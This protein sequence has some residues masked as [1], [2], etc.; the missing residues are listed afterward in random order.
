[1]SDSSYGSYGVGRVSFNSDSILEMLNRAHTIVIRS[2]SGLGNF[3]VHLGNVTG[4]MIFL[5]HDFSHSMYVLC[6]SQLPTMEPWPGVQGPLL[7]DSFL[8]S[9]WI[10][11]C[12]YLDLPLNVFFIILLSS[13]LHGFLKLSWNHTSPLRKWI[14][15]LNSKLPS[16]ISPSL[17]SFNTYLFNLSLI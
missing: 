14:V 4:T 8:V 11:T 9:S 3:N 12:L 10:L 7:S 15:S 1:M 6:K 17:F 13:F 5:F 2:P 16:L